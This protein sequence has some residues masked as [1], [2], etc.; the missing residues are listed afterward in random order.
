MCKYAS[1]CQLCDY[2]I[3]VHA[4]YENMQDVKLKISSDC[5][6]IGSMT[7]KPIVVDAMKE[8]MAPKEKSEIYHMMDEHP[9]PEGCTLYQSI[10]DAIGKSLGRYYEVA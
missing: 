9:H 3:E 2:P 5:P 8:L 1:T 4:E 7:D 10:I 6:N